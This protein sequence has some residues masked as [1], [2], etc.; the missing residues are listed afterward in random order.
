M[1]TITEHLQPYKYQ[2][3]KVFIYYCSYA[4]KHNY[5]LLKI[6]NFSRLLTDLQLINTQTLIS[7][8]DL[9]FYA[10][11]NHAGHINFKTFT[12]IL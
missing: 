1:E 8:C 12:E 7:H 9:I 6:Q 3:Q 5:S 11:A 10:K 2:L 4:D